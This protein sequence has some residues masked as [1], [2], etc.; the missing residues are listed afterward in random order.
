MRE[1]SR[2]LYVLKYLQEQTDEQHPASIRQILD[3]L[4]QQG[5]TAHRRTIAGDIQTLLDFGVDIVTV[6]STQNLYFI[7]ERHFELPEIK[8]LIDAVLS[9]KSITPKKSS[10]LAGK[11]CELV[12]AHQRSGFAEAAHIAGRVTSANE[13][14][15]LVT[16]TIHTAITQN[17][18]V[19]F[20]Y[21]ELRADQRKVLK[22]NG[23]RYTLS[24]YKLLWNEDKYYVI[25]HSPRHRKIVTFRVDR[26]CEV[27][28]SEKDAVPCPADFDIAIFCR[29]VFGMYDGKRISVVLKCKQRL[30]KVLVDKFG[31]DVHI[32]L[33][34]DDWIQAMVAV[35]I[36]PTF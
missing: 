11:L 9:S 6:K 23:R 21:Y 17:K 10:V 19:S 3:Y 20:K 33:V 35:S 12:S 27:A 2:I 29:Q 25:G 26:I 8:L 1:T 7:G 24:P 4:E 22:H 32:A 15:Y 28:I 18:Q 34:D 36:S 31:A 5:M 30:M 14:I 13:G 16:D